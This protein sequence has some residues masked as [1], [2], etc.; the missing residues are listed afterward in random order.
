MERIYEMLKE[1]KPEFDFYSSENY[2]SDGFL[3]SFDIVL[4]TNMLEE[5]Y[6]IKIDGLDIIPENFANADSIMQLV[7]KS[8]Q[9]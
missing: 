7:E 2:I 8:K 1:I 6:N 5:N 3:D 9:G 4:L